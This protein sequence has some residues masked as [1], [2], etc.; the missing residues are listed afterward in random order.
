M[1]KGLSLSPNTCKKKT[2]VGCGDAAP[3]ANSSSGR[4]PQRFSRQL[5]DTEVILL[6]IS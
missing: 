3:S 6:F 4:T 1:M 5:Y 2:G